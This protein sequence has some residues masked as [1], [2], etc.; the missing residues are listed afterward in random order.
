MGSFSYLFEGICDFF[1]KKYFTYCQKKKKKKS[2]KQNCMEPEAGRL[3]GIQVVWSTRSLCSVWPSLWYLFLVP[4]GCA[5]VPLCSLLSAFL[6]VPMPLC[7]CAFADRGTSLGPFLTS[8][9]VA[10]AL[11]LFLGCQI[12]CFPSPP[13]YSFSLGREADG[14]T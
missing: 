14:R 5:F 12:P 4:C 10:M 1:L 13:P 6:P 3:C 11:T 7:V 8:L 2:P 9:S